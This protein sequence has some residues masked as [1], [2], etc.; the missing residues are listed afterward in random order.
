MSQHIC[1]ITGAGGLVGSHLAQE[2]RSRGY[3]VKAL[4]RPG[5]DASFLENLGVEV[6]RGDLSDKSLPPEATQG[7][8]LVFHCAAKVGDWGPIEEYRKVN[9]EGLRKLLNSLDPTKLQ[10]FVHF[11]SLGVYEARHHDQ[12]D[13]STPPP[14]LHMVTPRPRWNQKNL[15][16]NTMLKKNIRWW[17][18]GRVLFMARVTELFCRE[19]WIV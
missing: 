19:S 10:R 2:C 14:E 4:I 12:T 18:S 17:F 6:V 13:E 9:V 3:Q 8:D 15:P 7:V 16:C 5:S 1:L 11:S